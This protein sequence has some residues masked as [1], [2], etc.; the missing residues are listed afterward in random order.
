MQHSFDVDVAAK[1]GIKEAILLHHI[2]FWITKNRANKAHIH[3]DK[4][5][6][7]NSY[8]A[9]CELFPYLNRDQIKR[10]LANLKNEKLIETGNFNKNKFDRTN[11][12]C[13]TEKGFILLEKRTSHSTG[14]NFP[15]EETDIPDGLDE[16]ALSLNKTDSKPDINTDNNPKPLCGETEPN[17]EQVPEQ[18]THRIFDLDNQRSQLPVTYQQGAEDPD[19]LA[20]QS[21]VKIWHHLADEMGFTFTNDEWYFIEKYARYKS[22]LN[23]QVIESHL[24]MLSKWANDGTD[25][26]E[27]LQLSMTT[28]TLVKAK[29]PIEYDRVGNRLL[30]PAI[31]EKRRKLI[32][33]ERKQKVS[34]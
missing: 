5:W 30:H 12:Y 20:K 22:Y 27:S 33:Q 21:K 6:T 19:E 15:M 31:A 24:L 32:E 16:P 18:T 10:V 3:D 13:L 11:W 28:K 2:H 9:F 7:Y 4:V 25:I 8:E 26:I 23:I 29:L 14:K 1:Y 34:A 17:Q